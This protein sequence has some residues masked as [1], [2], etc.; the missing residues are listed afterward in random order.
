MNQV[1]ETCLSERCLLC[2]VFTL[3]DD[4]DRERLKVRHES[5]QIRPS[6]S[7]VVFGIQSKL[8]NA[9]VLSQQVPDGR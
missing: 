1:R 3:T 8:H 7:S 6:R 9:F 5:G 2:R 4:V